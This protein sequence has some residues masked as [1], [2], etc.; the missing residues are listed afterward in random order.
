[1]TSKKPVVVEKNPNIAEGTVIL[2][3]EIGKVTNTRK[4]PSK[5]EAIQTEVDRKMLADSAGHDKPAFATR[6]EQAKV[7]LAV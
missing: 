3:M 7:A 2:S 1:M 5:T 6:A 4:L